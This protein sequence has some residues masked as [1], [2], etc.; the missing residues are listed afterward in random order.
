MPTLSELWGTRSLA[1]LAAQ[2]GIPFRRLSEYAAGTRP[3]TP[4]DQATLAAFFAI[5]PA[6]LSQSGEPGAPSRPSR[7]IPPAAQHPRTPA[8]RAPRPPDAPP[9]TDVVTSQGTAEARV[10]GVLQRHP[11]P[12]Q[13]K[14]SPADAA[15]RFWTLELLVPHQ[16]L[17][18]E[19]AYPPL[20]V[21]CSIY[22]RAFDPY[23]W[24]GPGDRVVVLGTPAPRPDHLHVA[25]TTLSTPRAER[26]K[27][28]L[29]SHQS[30]DSESEAGLRKLL[31]D[32]WTRLIAQPLEEGVQSKRPAWA[33]PATAADGP[34]GRVQVTVAGQLQADPLMELDE[35]GSGIATLRF[36]IAPPEHAARLS[37]ARY[38]VLLRP[39]ALRN[40]PWL[41]RGD[42]V[43]VS[44]DIVRTGDELLTEATTLR[45][46]WE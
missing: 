18:G 9:P 20:L 17:R 42:S 3:Y 24:L 38:R 41:Q 32:D 25:A 33:A 46:A 27:Q 23:R 8:P 34:H 7:A 19:P 35:Q 36:E 14:G 39:R 6:S 31:G 21:R 11:E 13:P 45:T 26:L 44:G 2:V 22:R 43:V 1:E 4:R 37:V 29:S 28:L 16:P 5:D 12:V 15:P 10:T 40:Y 30:G